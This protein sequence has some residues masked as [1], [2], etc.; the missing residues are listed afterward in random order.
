VY[1]NDSA[2]GGVSWPTPF[3]IPASDPH[4]A[5]DDISAVVAFGSNK[6]GVMWSDQLTGT[7]Y[8]ATRT[9]GTSPTAASSWHDQP[10]IKGKGMADDHLNLKTLQSDASGRVWAAVKTSLND[11]STDTGQP[12]LLLL[13]FKPGTGAFTQS[14]ISTVADCV[15][16]PQV[17][18]DDQHNQVHV[19]QTAP[20]ST[21]TG[22]AFS[23]VAGSIY[24]KTADMSNPVFTSGRGTPIIENSASPN[25]NNVTTTKQGVNSSTGIVVLASNDVTKRYWFADESLGS[26]TTAPVA[27]FTATP[28]SGTSPLT[29]Q[30]SDTSTGAPTSWAWDFGDGTTAA[31]QNP[32]H[33]YTITD[34]QPHTYNVS[35]TVTNTGGGNTIT[36]AGLITVSPAS[37]PTGIS[38]G[39]SSTSYAAV[40]AGTVTLARPAGAGP[41]DVLIAGITADL[42]PTM[43]SA[44]AGWQPL[45][46]ALSINSSST[47]G[48][49]LLAYYH[50]VGA[51]DPSTDTWTLSTPVKWGG[52][53]TVYHGVNT[54]TPLDS[55]TVTAV[56][57]SYSATS[58]TLPSITTISNGDML[59]G[60]V[61]LDSGTPLVSPPTGWTQRWQAAG[62]QIAEQA[63]QPQATAGS[64]GT[65][66]WTLSAGRALGGWRTALKPAG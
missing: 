61:G 54:T 2:A 64:S 15:S 62:G 34:G 43:T 50:V 59:I 21:V 37:T 3:V 38:T 44:P 52:G 33:T 51:S 55:P 24:E 28:T 49:R 48:A 53:E 18:L 47:S 5:P 35:L 7:V 10:A 66:T 6:I 16:R 1:V 29:V 57:T 56:N 11:T 9:D 22:C 36:R 65:A 20:S 32:S 31:T 8:W 26:S 14:T 25:L 19:F 60:G 45:V 23:G 4:P 39:A 17:L 58:L 63:D 12:Q 27:G 30:F 40:A 42:N 13:V 46:N 41:G